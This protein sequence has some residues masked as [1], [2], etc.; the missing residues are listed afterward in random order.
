[1][2]SSTDTWQRLST[3]WTSSFYFTSSVTS[4]SSHVSHFYWL[5]EMITSSRRG[6][7][8]SITLTPSD[9]SG[10]GCKEWVRGWGISCQGVYSTNDPFVWQL[11]PGWLEEEVTL[12]LSS[13]SIPRGHTMEARPPPVITRHILKRSRTLTPTTRE[14]LRLLRY[15]A[16]ESCDWWVSRKFLQESLLQHHHHPQDSHNHEHNYPNALHVIKVEDM[17][18]P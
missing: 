7:S 6:C 17:K 3:S 11:F 5:A 4:P 16:S 9:A 1:M 15:L 2:L 10:S 8:T 18:P 13:S 12:A 14:I